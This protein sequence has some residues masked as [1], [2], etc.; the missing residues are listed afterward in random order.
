[1]TI[2]G[3]FFLNVKFL[4]FFSQSNGNFPEGQVHVLIGLW[5]VHFLKGV[6]CQKAC[7]IV[8]HKLSDYRS[9]L[10]SKILVQPNYYTLKPAWVWNC[11]FIEVGISS[12]HCSGVLR[13]MIFVRYSLALM[14][15]WV[16]RVEFKIMN[17]IRD[18]L[19]FFF[20]KICFGLFSYA[21]MGNI[22]FM[23]GCPILS[24][25]T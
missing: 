19:H 10:Y 1:M 13:F 24:A 6:C 16:K 3:Y 23:P 17:S 5:N 21:S 22:L 8:N 12:I 2:F 20:L 18:K 15:S 25:F 7:R 9:K 11:L 14:R 4:A